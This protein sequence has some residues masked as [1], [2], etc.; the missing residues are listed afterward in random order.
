[1]KWI[2]TTN[3]AFDYKIVNEIPVKFNSQ[4]IYLEG[5]KN[6]FWI[7]AFVCPCGCQEIIYLNLLKNVDPNWKIRINFWGKISIYPSVWRKVGC[8]SHFIICK[9]KVIWCVNREI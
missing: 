7:A 6:N 4:T 3:R 1:M 5:E 8:K 9:S 2:N